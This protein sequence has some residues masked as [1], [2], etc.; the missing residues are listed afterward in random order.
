MNAKQLET[1]KDQILLILADY[2]DTKPPA[3]AA[4]HHR[5]AIARRIIDNV[6]LIS[7]EAREKKARKS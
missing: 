5:I 4:E 7:R 6:K 3:L 2:R 1:L